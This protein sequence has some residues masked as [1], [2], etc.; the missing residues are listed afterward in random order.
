MIGKYAKP[1]RLK[2]KPRPNTDVKNT[3][4]Q[5]RK[6][7]EAT[8]LFKK[9]A[10]MLLNEKEPMPNALFQKTTFLKTKF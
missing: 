2:M 8:L 6:D 9:T 1:N 10:N 3:E 4:T 5:L 7:A